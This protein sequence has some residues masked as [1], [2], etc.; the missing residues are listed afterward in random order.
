MEKLICA[1]LYDRSS[2]MTFDFKN[3]EMVD[4]V[5]YSFAKVTDDGLID[6]SRLFHLDQVLALKN[7]HRRVTVSIGGWGCDGFSQ[8]VSTKEKTKKFV[9]SIVK[10][11]KEVG[12]DGIDIDWEYP[13]S[14]S[15]GIAFSPDDTPNFT[16]FL[17]L[18][19]AGLD[20]IRPNL[21]LTVAVGAGLKCVKDIEI[22]I[23]K[24]YIDYL[25]IMTYDLGHSEDG[26]Y[27]HHTNL[28]KA[29]S[30]PQVSGDM[31]VKAYHEAGMPYEKI[32]LGSATYGKCFTLDRNDKPTGHYPYWRIE[33][34]LVH[35]KNVKF[36]WDEE[37]H[38]PLAILNEHHYVTYDD[39]RSEKEKCDY[40]KEHNMAGIM[41]WEYTSDK[42]G[43]LLRTMY[44]NLK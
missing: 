3:M 12:L 4:V 19:R 15:A 7:N 21:L 5:N 36:I 37:A 33:S 11:T 14:G 31:A 38:A 16:Y 41:Y 20:S 43:T 23:I 26:A 2:E 6:T 9:D 8:A 39:P 27:R 40:I 28:Y 32:I 44:E 34:E 25:N 29:A 22:S 30:D 10:F 35:D 1:Y 24:D 17:K 18:L 13:N 42:F